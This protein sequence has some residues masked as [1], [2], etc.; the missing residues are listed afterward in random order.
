LEGGIT[1]G[2]DVGQGLEVGEPVALFIE[3][4]VD[5]KSIEDVVF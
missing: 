3:I 1:K 5:A 4:K 2:G